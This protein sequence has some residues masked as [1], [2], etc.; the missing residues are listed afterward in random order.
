MDWINRADLRI[1][2]R[3]A[4]S[5][6]AAQSTGDGYETWRAELLRGL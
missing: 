4:A 6:R 5:S 2:L 1:A 3:D